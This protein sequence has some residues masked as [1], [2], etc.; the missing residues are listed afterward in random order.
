ADEAE[1]IVRVL[2][3]QGIDY[4]GLLFRFAITT[5]EADFD[6]RARSSRKENSARVLSPAANRESTLRD[7]ARL[8]AGELDHRRMLTDVRHRLVHRDDVIAANR[9][10]AV[11]VAL[12]VSRGECLA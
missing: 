11:E 1:R 2:V 8:I 4:D 7:P 9:P 3:R 12:R 6:F 5:G 10:P